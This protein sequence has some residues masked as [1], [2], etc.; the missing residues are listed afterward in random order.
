MKKTIS[1]FFLGF[2]LIFMQSAWAQTVTQQNVQIVDEN[3]NSQGIVLEPGAD[4]RPYGILLNSTAGLGQAQLNIDDT[5]ISA[6]R[7]ITMRDPF[8]PDGSASNVTI[9]N[10][11][12]LTLYQSPGANSPLDLASQG[13]AIHRIRGNLSVFLPADGGY[14]GSLTNAAGSRGTLVV[15]GVQD[16][17]NASF[18]LANPS[19]QGLRPLNLFIVGQA[20]W[21]P[22]EGFGEQFGS[23]LAT[24][25]VENNGYL[26]ATVL[27]IGAA[28]ESAP[29]AYVEGIVTMSDFSRI[30]SCIVFVG[31][32]L[33]PFPNQ[34]EA[35]GTLSLTSSNSQ[36]TVYRNCAPA[37]DPS[38]VP[39]IYVGPRGTL[40]GIGTIAGNVYNWGGLIAPGNSPGIM[41]IEGD[42]TMDAG[43][44]EIEVGNDDIADKLIVSGNSVFNGGTLALKFIDGASA[45]SGQV[46]SFIE[47]STIQGASN[48]SISAEGVEGFEA[49]LN[50][51]GTI[52]VLNGGIP[53]SDPSQL[54]VRPGEPNELNI[55]S[56]QIFPVA[57]IT[58]V[59]GPISEPEAIDLSS[60]RFGSSGDPLAQIVEK[61][62]SIRDANG[63]GTE[64]L[65]VWF[66]TAETGIDC[67]DSEVEIIGQNLSGEQFSAID[68]V[69]VS[70]CQ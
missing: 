28:L 31:P 69:I 11:G 65:I 46:L 56:Q 38:L 8:N 12:F 33:E 54:E 24:V 58:D 17:L 6:S 34:N 22:E 26:T 61:K 40:D 30:F 51:D 18:G 41:N 64:D 27:Y 1:G 20:I 43:V 45:D 59:E 25:R 13:E 66:K 55:K 39:G 29:D 23:S 48:L 15:G 32:P 52:L 62:T 9:E 67:D 37:P 10:G 68:Y 53:T 7:L 44:I 21:L 57:L 47:S 42:F 14:G 70:G 19:A 35:N 60:L 50:E 16:P 63:D 36:V 4:V 3:F 2:M 49:V 5:Q